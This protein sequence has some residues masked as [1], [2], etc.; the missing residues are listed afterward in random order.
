MKE[1]MKKYVIFS[2]IF[3]MVF[4][5]CFFGS[6]EFRAAYWKKAIAIITGVVNIFDSVCKV[7]EKVVEFDS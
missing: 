2:V 3:D 4:A 1:K 7:A 5:I 6:E